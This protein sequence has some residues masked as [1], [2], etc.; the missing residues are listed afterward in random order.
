MDI[1]TDLGDFSG[2]CRLFPLSRV[3]LF[4]H[5]IL[6]LHIF[7]PRYRQMT[8]DALEG[9][10]LVTIVQIQPPPAGTPWTEPMPIMDVACVGK[11]VRHEHLPD[12]RYNMLLLGCK[13]IRLDREVTSSK[14]YRVAEGTILDDE[15]WRQPPPEPRI[16]LVELCA[17]ALERHHRLD[18]DLSRIL[19]SDL[20]LGI[21]SDIVAQ[22]L[23]LPPWFKQVLLG[24]TRVE[25]RVG[26]LIQALRQ[27]SDRLGS[28]RMYPPPFSS[29]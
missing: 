14:L 6:P 17:R 26:K 11:I 20:S 5:A 18:D 29:N 3:V 4:P 27:A 15:E 10:K 24:E 19:H 9:D 1:H 23:E 2:V 28:S 12:G 25:A 22:A 13:R 16:E 21:L 8:R 7:E